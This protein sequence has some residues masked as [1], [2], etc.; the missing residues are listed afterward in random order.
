MTITVAEGEA[1]AARWLKAQ[2]D[3][4]HNGKNNHKDTMQDLVAD[5]MK[6]SWSDGNQVSRSK[7]CASGFDYIKRYLTSSLFMSQGEG[8]PSIL[9][10]VISNTWGPL[11]SEWMYEKPFVCVDTD[12]SE[13]IMMLHLTVN[14]SGGLPDETNLFQAYE[15]QRIKLN[16][17]MKV[18]YWKAVWDNNEDPE[19]QKAIKMVLSKLG[20][21][22]PPA[23]A[24][25]FTTSEGEAY[26]NDFLE[27]FSAG[28]KKNNHS[29]TIR[30]FYSSGKMSWEWSDGSKGEGTVDEYMDLLTS[31]SC[32]CLPIAVCDCCMQLMFVLSPCMHLFTDMG[33]FGGL[34]A[35]FY[36]S[37]CCGPCKC[38]C[39]PG[40]SRIR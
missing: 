33:S 3:G 14:V 20:K 13:V 12:A 1:F 18:T 24:A 21:E 22:L 6:W 31:V 30:K 26:A 23:V 17:E 40:S 8:T 39:Y 37:H 27:A 4:F 9:F 38:T 15:A 29:E 28:F 32:A 10:D 11:V 36:A 34:L 16:D 7:S 2:A 5:N 25:P 19:A 35:L